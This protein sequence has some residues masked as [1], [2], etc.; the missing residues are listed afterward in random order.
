MNNHLYDKMKAEDK[1]YQAYF[2]LK[3]NRLYY[4]QIKENTKLSHSS[5]Q[6]VLDRLIKSKILI[7]EKTKSNTFYKIKN[8]KLFALKF[9]EIAINKFNNLNLGIR[10]PLR[11][12]IKE[13]PQTVF[14]IVLFG[15]SSIKKEEPGSDIDLLIVTSNKQNFEDLKK[16]INAVSNHPLST[17][18]CN[19]DQFI[20]NKDH[21]IIQARK[22]GFP[23]FKENNFYEV[24][25]NEN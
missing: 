25:L 10:S 19:I 8:K 2:K 13:I 3:E 6:N 11:N 18:Q 7:Q 16:S 14:T 24:M 23:I 12:F 17:F 15:S 9:S 21:I 5:L 22:K 20:E 1:I 4:N